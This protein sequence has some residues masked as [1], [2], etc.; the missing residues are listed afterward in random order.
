VFIGKAWLVSTW[1]CQDV[2]LA[3]FS[4]FIQIKEYERLSVFG[5]HLADPLG[6]PKMSTSFQGPEGGTS[7]FLLQGYA[8]LSTLFFC[9]DTSTVVGSKNGRRGSVPARESV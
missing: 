4:P 1:R 8:N 3:E 6:S 7:P 2:D 5:D 9:E